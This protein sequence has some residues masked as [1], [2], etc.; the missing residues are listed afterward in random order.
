MEQII[1]RYKVKPERV[2]ENEELV[3]A[4]YAE[5][6]EKGPTTFH[7]ATFKLADGV[8]FVH[9][10]AGACS[11]PPAGPCGCRTSRSTACARSPSARVGSARPYS[12]SRA[13]GRPAGAVF[14]RVRKQ[15]RS[16]SGSRSYDC[17]H[18]RR[19]ASEGRPRR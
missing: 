2:A 17:L 14:S 15:A 8:S 1:V 11:A 5:L 3:R 10:S 12:S 4:V 9:V 7:Y 16:P 6:G 13:K 18:E 19:R